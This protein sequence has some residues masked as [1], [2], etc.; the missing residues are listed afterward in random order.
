MTDE[1]SAKAL[2]LL[3]QLLDVCQDMGVPYL[4]VFQT[5]PEMV[6]ASLRVTP[7]TAA[8]LHLAATCIFTD[9]QLDAAEIPEAKGS[10]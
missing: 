3:R 10:S 9:E 2:P 5:A 8:H 4:V 1:F 7:E 6:H